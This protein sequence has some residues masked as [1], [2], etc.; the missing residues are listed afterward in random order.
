MY[1][2]ID[3]EQTLTDLLT[4]TDLQASTGSDYISKSDIAAYR[5]VKTV[6]LFNITVVL[7]QYG[8]A[9]RQTLHTVC[10]LSKVR[11]AL[12][13]LTGC[14]KYFQTLDLRD[15]LSVST[16]FSWVSSDRVADRHAAVDFWLGR[17]DQW[18]R[19]FVPRQQTGGEW[20]R[21]ANRIRRQKK[22][23]IFRS[24]YLE[25]VAQW[26]ASYQITCSI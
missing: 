14:P 10:D 16:C 1:W 26:I 12:F 25:S 4:L 21:P 6:H 18:W 15:T 5:L 22:P 17:H 13:V 24:S 9:I 7:P 20:T 8:T 11:T 3:T 19:R 23:E 2:L